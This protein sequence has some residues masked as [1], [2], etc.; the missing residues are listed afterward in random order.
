MPIR[1][2]SHRYYAMKAKW[3]G[4]DVLDYWDRNAPLPNSHHAATSPGTRPE[5]A[6]LVGLFEASAPE[7]TAIT[8]PLLR[9]MAGSTRR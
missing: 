9:P 6:G 1:R 3:L 4:Q 5:G 2:I 8:E 7:K